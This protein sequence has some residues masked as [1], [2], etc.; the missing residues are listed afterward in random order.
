MSGMTMSEKILAR[1]SGTPHVRAGQIVDGY[2]DLLYMHEMLA[3]AIK[4]FD[5][6]GVGRIWDPSKCVV[7]VDHWVPPPNEQ[8][9]RMHQAIREFCWKYGI[10]RFHDVGDHGIIHQLVVER[11]YV[12]PGML[13]IGSDSHTN[14]AGAMGA[15]AAGIGVTETAAVMA[16]GKLWLKV[17][18][19]LDVRVDGRLS[20]RTGAKDV[21]LRVI[22]TTGDDG[23]SYKAVEFHGGTI[24]DFPMNERFVLSNMTTEMGAKA[25]MVPADGTTREYLRELG[26]ESEA[27]DADSDARYLRAYD[28]DVDGMGPQVACPNNPANVKPVEEVAGTKID[29]AFVG[30]CTN[31][32]IQ[33]LRAAAE[34]LKG[35]KVAARVRMVVT[36]ASQAIY[37][38]AMKEGL[39]EVFLDAGATFTSSTCGPC[40]GGHMGV[41]APKEVCIS[42]TNRNY[43]GRMGSPESQVYLGSPYTVAASALYGQITDPRGA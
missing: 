5:E 26:A 24:H 38:Q 34:I 21:I 42:S 18:E 23:A 22:Q 7:T 40:F 30:S 1:A 37:R 29:M 15:F 2:V 9:A 17:P 28:I 39:V 32:R 33:D 12:R 10:E 25:G 16:T 31:A 19:T 43:P 13:V 20:S 6:I 36:P 41:L 14:M 27:L 4:P 8:I 11:G 35:E 3:L